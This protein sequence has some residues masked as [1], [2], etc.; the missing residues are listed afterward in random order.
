VQRGTAYGSLLPE[1][2]EEMMN[3]TWWYMVDQVGGG[4]PFPAWL[5]GTWPHTV[6]PS[7]LPTPPHRSHDTDGVGG[8]GEGH[9]EGRGEGSGVG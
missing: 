5:D 2:T 3:A 9:G 4:L 7:P 8:E 6:L 1:G